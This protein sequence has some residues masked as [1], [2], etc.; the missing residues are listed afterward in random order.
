MKRYVVL[1]GKWDAVTAVRIYDN[2]E[3][4]IEAARGMSGL[5]T[6]GVWSSVEQV[7]SAMGMQT[8]KQIWNS[9]DNL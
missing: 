4:A 5:R 7:R 8:S 3:S 9:G 6:G 1:V 2:D